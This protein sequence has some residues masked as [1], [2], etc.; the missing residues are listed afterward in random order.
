[1][2]KALFLCIVLGIAYGLVSLAY[3]K[4]GIVFT[5]ETSQPRKIL[6]VTIIVALGVMFWAMALFF[7]LRGIANQDRLMCIVASFALPGVYLL[8]AVFTRKRIKA[9]IIASEQEEAVVRQ[10]QEKYAKR[11]EEARIK[12]EQS[13]QAEREN[14]PERIVVSVDRSEETLACPNCNRVQRSDRKF[15]YNCGVAFED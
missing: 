1:M 10:E 6:L 9:E 15:C 12:W 3:G 8:W 5:S 14:P 4:D 11:E 7:W 2:I 13:K